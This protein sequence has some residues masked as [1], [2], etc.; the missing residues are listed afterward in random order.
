MK[1][2][3]CTSLILFVLAGLAGS[4]ATMAAGEAAAGESAR[5]SKGGVKEFLQDLLPTA[6]QKHPLQR[7][8]V[9][10]EMTPE[11]RKRRIPTTREPMKYFSSPGTFVQTGW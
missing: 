9:I 6:W 1:R 2:F 11:G 5:S 8:S 3:R 4:T 7:Y 10:T